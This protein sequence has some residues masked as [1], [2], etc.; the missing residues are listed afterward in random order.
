MNG[1][2]TARILDVLKDRLSHTVPEIHRLAGTS[3]LNSRIAELRK[4]GYDIECVR[5]PGPPG[6]E[7]Y[8]YRMLSAPGE[9]TNLQIPHAETESLYQQLPLV[10]IQ[11]ETR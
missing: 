1:S 6:P 11:E 2:Q 3:R 8:S 4:R 7:R 9:R 10:G 5:E